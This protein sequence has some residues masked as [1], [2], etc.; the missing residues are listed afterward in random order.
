MGWD[1]VGRR[2]AAVGRQWVGGS[3][4]LAEAN[5]RLS[6][7]GCVR[8]SVELPSEVAW[9][10]NMIGVPWPNVD[11][12]QVRAFAG[13]VRQFAGSVENTHQAATSTI[14]QM[15]SAYSGNSYEQLVSTW[16]RMSNDHMTEL[17]DACNVVAEALDLAADGIVGAKVAAIGELVGLA[18]SFIAD[19]AAAVATFGLA[20]AGLALIEEA[21]KK[22]MD[23]LIQ[24]LEM[25]I[26]AQV[27][28][29]AVAPLEQ[30]VERALGGLVFKGLESAL[31][32]PSG[33]GG[34]AVGASFGIVPGELLGH[35][36]TLQGH[37]DAVAG[38]AAT[39]AANVSSLNF[40]S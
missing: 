8:V 19:Q 7:T 35:A 29:A 32:V 10:L 31:G 17:V 9:F 24:Q 4:R 40:G 3:G 38:H 11:E 20:E 22:L 37:A 25:M 28:E 23:M 5:R 2:E 39:L 14:Q 1:G 33:G 6:A 16:A 27:L 21:G 15:G 26:V 36:T 34:G 18:A 30:V 12:D 13:H